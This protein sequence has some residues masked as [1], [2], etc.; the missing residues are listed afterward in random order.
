LAGSVLL[1][2]DSLRDSCIISVNSG[3]CLVEFWIAPRVLRADEAA[4][5]SQLLAEVPVEPHTINP[6]CD[7]C[8]ITRFEF[9]GR[10]EDLNPCATGSAGYL[11][12]MEQLERLLVSMLQLG[13]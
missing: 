2:Y 6:A 11:W 4:A 5:L 13:D 8:L 3:R 12:R 10:V 7:P 9:G 1:G